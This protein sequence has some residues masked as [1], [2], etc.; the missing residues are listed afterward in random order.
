MT[1]GRNRHRIST[2]SLPFHFLN[3]SSGIPLAKT[4]N[5]LKKKTKQ[6]NNSVSQTRNLQNLQIFLTVYETPDLKSRYQQGD[7]LQEIWGRVYSTPLSSPLVV[8]RNMN[9]WSFL[10]WAAPSDLCFCLHVDF[11]SLRLFMSFPF[12]IGTL[13][14]GFRFHFNPIRSHLNLWL[15]VRA[16]TLFPNKIS[17][18]GSG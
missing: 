1:Q 11:I 9:P 14:I 17:F 16:K 8:A 12:P 15:N 5:E 18:R 7:F 2:C 4:S 10:V 13:V 6:N 3:L